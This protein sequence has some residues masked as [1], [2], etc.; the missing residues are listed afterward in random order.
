MKLPWEKLDSG[1]HPIFIHDGVEHF[2]LGE[3][4]LGYWVWE[5]EQEADSKQLLVSE[6]GELKS[7]VKDPAV[8]VKVIERFKRRK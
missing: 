6:K 8:F 4:P 5:S 3:S 1:G 2:Y 7:V